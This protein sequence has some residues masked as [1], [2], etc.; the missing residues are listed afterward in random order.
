MITLQQFFSKNDKYSKDAKH[1]KLKYFVMKEVQKQK[2]INKVYYQKPYDSLPFDK[3][4]TTQD[5]Y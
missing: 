3:R 2:S 4:I 1:V 5:I